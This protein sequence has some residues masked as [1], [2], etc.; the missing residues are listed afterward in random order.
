M[1]NLNR[2]TATS[3]DQQAGVALILAIVGLLLLIAVAGGMILLSN[4]ETSVDANYRDQQIAMF[5]AKA[6]LQEARD[7]MLASNS[8]SINSSLPAVLPGATGVSALYIV[9]SGVQPWSSSNTVTTQMGGV[10]TYDKE[11]A[12]EL[13]QTSLPSGN[14][15]S[16][17]AS[18]SNYSGPSG[19]PLPY[20]WVRINLKV[21]K[22]GYTS[23]GT[24]YYVDGNS[25]NAA[26][27]VCFDPTSGVQHEVVISAASCQA[28]NPSYQNVY[29]ITSYAITPSGTI[30]MMQTEVAPFTFNLQFPSALTMPGPVG[31]FNPPSSSGYC[32]DGSDTSQAT[33]IS[34]CSF[35]QPPAVPSC[36]SSSG[37]GP[38]VGVSTGNDNA[39]N[40]TNVNYVTGQIPTNRQGNYPGTTGTSPSVG[41]PALPG[42]LANPSTLQ[43]E[44]QL[45][46]QNANV[47]L[48]CSG[49]GGGSYTYSSIVSAPGS[50]W[51]NMSGTQMSTNPQ[52]TYVNGNMDISGQTS[53]SGI[54]VVTGNLTY[55]GASSWNGI[56]LVVGNGLTTYL[57]NGGGN[58]QFNGAI[59]VANTAGTNC[60]VGQTSCYGPA[61]FTINGGGGNG[62]YYNSC[63]INYV[64]KPQWYQLLSVKE[65]SN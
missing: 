27:Q 28:A 38:A 10:S 52:V 45:I 12:N 62:V 1:N 47:C 23:S 7:R 3:R 24:P 29:E 35:T 56:I 55:N 57:Q 34:G 32:M 22:S 46:Q 25:A 64:Q 11:F 50:L 58:G 61:D 65:I 9:A 39:G 60:A 13:G 2:P 6:G 42:S 37:G 30:R 40:Q 44:L 36:S 17:V 5:A 54:L 21:D 31:S 41:T 4:S 48:G 53:G 8:N 43:Q 19:N 20:Q 18:N 49:S 51:T 16:S 26:K 59:F 14:W 63:W 15:Y 33:S